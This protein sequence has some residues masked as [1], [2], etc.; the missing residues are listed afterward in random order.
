MGQIFRRRSNSIVQVLLISGVVMG[1]GPLV[2]WTLIKWSSWETEVGVR[3][4]RQS[5]LVINI[6]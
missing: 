6:M 3:W 2:F 4:I 1:A 5:H